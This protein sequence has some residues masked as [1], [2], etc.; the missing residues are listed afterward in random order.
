MREYVCVYVGV[1]VYV[2][3]CVYMCTYIYIYKGGMCASACASVK[4]RDRGLTYNP[5]DSFL[6]LSATYCETSWPY[7]ITCALPQS[8]YHR[9]LEQLPGEVCPEE[10]CCLAQ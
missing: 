2:C 6:H 5:C 4:M 7:H 10:S 1:Y 3:V 9:C 8:L